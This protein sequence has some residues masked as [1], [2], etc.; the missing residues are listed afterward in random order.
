[1]FDGGPAGGGARHHTGPPPGHAAHPTCDPV[2]LSRV[3]SLPPN[4]WPAVHRLATGAAW[5]PVDDAAA[6]AFVRRVNEEALLPLLFAESDLPANVQ[7]AMRGMRAFERAQ[8][9]RAQILRD[10]LDQ[11]KQLLGDEQFAV[12][13]GSD[14]AYRLYPRPELRPMA[15]VDVLVPQS[16]YERV[17]R[18]LEDDGVARQFVVDATRDHAYHQAVFT[19]ADVTMEIHQRFTQSSR[20]R[21]D[22]DAIWS[23]VVDA[24]LHDSDALAYL[25]IT[26]AVNYLAGPMIGIVDLWLLS[27]ALESAAERA[28][29]WRARHAFYAM[30][31]RAALLVPDFR[32]ERFTKIAASLVSAS[33]RRFLDRYVIPGA[34]PGPKQAP[35]RRTQLWRKF[36]LLDDNIRRAA[37]I[38]EHARTAMR[39]KFY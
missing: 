7:S 37:L 36:W 16:A 20:H 21:I 31:R 33:S 35:D 9:R 3:F 38:G 19:I 22:Y 14:F 8:A 23:R 2:I 15:D 32:A 1:M 4:L 29:E 34:A 39:L 13:K 12:I 10:A 27:D 25:G 17:I 11:T 30:L 28:I 18:K 26:T 5:P 24:R 6:M